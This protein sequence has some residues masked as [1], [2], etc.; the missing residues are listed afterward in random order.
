[1]GI[2]ERRPERGFAMFRIICAQ[3]GHEFVSR[4]RSWQCPGCL[5]AEVVS[6]EE[7]DVWIPAI[8]VRNTTMPSPPEDDGGVKK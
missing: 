5:S 6:F 2:D 1:M 7:P 4:T 3:C 8:N